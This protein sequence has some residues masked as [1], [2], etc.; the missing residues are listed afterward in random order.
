[1]NISPTDINTAGLV[2]DIIGAWLVAKEVTSQ[3]KGTKYKSDPTW[4]GADD[5]P[6][7]SDEYKKWESI[8]YRVMWAGLVF[9]TIGFI[10]QIVSNYI[11]N[12]LIG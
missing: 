11:P 9:L 8:K 7:D 6:E 10:L 3:F 5:P 1:M 12:V 4:D 2:C